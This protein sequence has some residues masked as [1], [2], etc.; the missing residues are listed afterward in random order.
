[1]YNMNSKILVSLLVI[2]LAA[3]AIGNG[4]TG[5]FFSDTAASTNNQI[6]AGSLNLQIYDGSAWKE[7]TTQTITASG[8]YP[9]STTPGR[10]CFMN[11]GTIPGVVTVATTYEKTADQA[12]LFA[13]NLAVTDAKLEGRNTGTPGTTNV[14]PY[15]A[16][17]IVDYNWY[18]AS[19]STNADHYAAAIADG[20]VVNINGTNYPTI[21]GLQWITLHYWN[22]YNGIDQAFNANDWQCEDLVITFY[23]SGQDQ[24]SLMGKT[25]TATITGNIKQSTAP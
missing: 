24:S 7:G 13:K 23:D 8:M 11:A 17:Q 6:T 16:Q 9:S 10:L 5:A 1:M 22:T 12:D 25:L 15:W 2:G 19:G 14:A 18:N 3:I 20:S 4:I 21:Y